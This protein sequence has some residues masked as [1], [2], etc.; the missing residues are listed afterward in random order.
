MPVI[1][2]SSAAHWGG[3]IAIAAPVPPRSLYESINKHMAGCMHVSCLL[4][5]MAGLH[6]AGAAALQRTK[7]LQ[8]DGDAGQALH[9]NGV[10]H[11][12]ALDDDNGDAL[13][14]D[15]QGTL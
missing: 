15:S 6:A 8:H 9:E 2:G 1:P 12:H 7:K 10:L 4:A 5:E 14:I 13:S 3:A 11:D